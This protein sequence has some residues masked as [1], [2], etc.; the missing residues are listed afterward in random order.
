[1]YPKEMATYLA[2]VRVCF[3]QLFSG[4]STQG[5]DGVVLRHKAFKALS[6]VS[7]KMRVPGLARP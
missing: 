7:A 4:E 6:K 3:E 1:M 2:T 5:G